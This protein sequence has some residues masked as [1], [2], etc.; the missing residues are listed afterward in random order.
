M[1][2][3]LATSIATMLAK[4]IAAAIKNSNNQISETELTNLIATNLVKIKA[5]ANTIQAEIDSYKG[6]K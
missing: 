1:D 5:I 6:G 4:E 3:V 2:L